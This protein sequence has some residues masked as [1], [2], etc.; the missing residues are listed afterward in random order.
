MAEYIDRV[1]ALEGVRLEE[2]RAHQFRCPMGADAASFRAG[3][4]TAFGLAHSIIGRQKATHMAPVVHAHWYQCD[5]EILCSHCGKGYMGGDTVHKVKE[6]LVNGEVYN[7]CP[8]CGAKMDGG[9]DGA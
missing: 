5:E 3:M 7:Y 4:L 9:A 6:L 1:P 2:D 8:N